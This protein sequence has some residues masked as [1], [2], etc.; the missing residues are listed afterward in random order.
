MFELMRHFHGRMINPFVRTMCLAI[1]V[2]LIVFAYDPLINPESRAFDNQV[3][4]VVERLFPLQG[5]GMWFGTAAFLALAAAVS[6]RFLVYLAGVGMAFI[7]QMTWF[8]GVLWARYAEGAILSTPG[9]GIWIL[10]LSLTSGTLLYPRPLARSEEPDLGLIQTEHGDVVHITEL[11]R[12]G[13][14]R[15][16]S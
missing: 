1:G 4:D 11:V 12:P 10:A 5:W 15:R 7:G 13:V 9:I 3:F 16:A 14:S 2:G 6:G 8:A